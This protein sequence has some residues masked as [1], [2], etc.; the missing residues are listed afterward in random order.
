MLT[1]ESPSANYTDRVVAM[2]L[3]DCRLH[4]HVVFWN[5]EVSTMLLTFLLAFWHLRGSPH[6]DICIRPT[7]FFAACVH[8]TWVL[9]WQ[10]FNKVV[11]GLAFG[12]SQVWVK[13]PALLFSATCPWASHSDG[14]AGAS[15][16][17][18]V[19]WGNNSSQLISITGH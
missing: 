8:F 7:L 16:F 17:P 1:L 4:Y 3:S 19:N 11:K 13:V 5:T 15:V 2:T 6:T 9:V 12:D 10:N 14:Q 18:S